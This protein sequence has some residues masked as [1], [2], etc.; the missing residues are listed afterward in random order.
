MEQIRNIILFRNKKQRSIKRFIIG[1]NIVIDEIL[2]S[3]CGKLIFH[4]QYIPNKT[5][6]Y[7]IKLFKLCSSKEYT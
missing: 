7:V 5:H 3:W 1:K 4:K 6:K 2:I